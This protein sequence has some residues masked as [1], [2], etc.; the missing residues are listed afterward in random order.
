MTQVTPPNFFEFYR[1]IFVNG[2]IFENFEYF[3]EL[4]ERSTLKTTIIDHW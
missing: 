2:I 4:F 1:A 3:S